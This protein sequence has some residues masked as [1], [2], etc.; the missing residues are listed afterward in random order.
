MQFF[1]N[2]GYLKN[3]AKTI[4]LISSHIILTVLTVSQSWLRDLE[5]AV[6][7][8]RIMFSSSVMTS[9]LFHWTI[10]EWFNPW[11]VFFVS[12]P[13][14]SSLFFKSFILLSGGFPT[15]LEDWSYIVR[16]L[17]ENHS[18][19]RWSSSL[20]QNMLSLGFWWWYRILKQKQKVGIH[21]QKRHSVESAQTS[22]CK[23]FFSISF[24]LNP[25][26]RDFSVHLLQSSWN[27]NL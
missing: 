22:T 23:S 27:Q 5:T 11:I 7:H 1:Q 3:T 2:S 6:A 17:V 26:L 14:K 10:L 15:I 21:T 4:A 20:T 19:S 18:Y 25:P 9:G 8:F 12:V 24:Q 13:Q 16:T